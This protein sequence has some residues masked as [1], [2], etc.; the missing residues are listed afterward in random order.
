[1]GE[2]YI[3][4]YFDRRSAAGVTVMVRNYFQCDAVSKVVLVQEKGR[5]NTAA[6][7]L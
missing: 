2:S 1:M 4:G 5:G 6:K 3:T 7:K